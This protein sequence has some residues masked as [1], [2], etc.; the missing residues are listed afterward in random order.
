MPS[1]PDYLVIGHICRDLYNGG[2]KLGGTAMFSALTARNLGHAVGIVTSYGSDLDVSG[3]PS[4][5]SIAA[6][7]SRSTRSGSAI[8]SDCAVAPGARTQ[9]TGFGHTVGVASFAARSREG[10]EPHA[11]WPAATNTVGCS[12]M[13]A[14]IWAHSQR[15]V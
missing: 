4:D 13:P 8:E 3:L 9:H 12:R 1:C 2:Y 7:R 11:N 15:I 10:A 14:T 6:H 5:I